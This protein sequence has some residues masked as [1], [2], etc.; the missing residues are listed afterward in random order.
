MLGF[1]D[2]I[3]E[4]WTTLSVIAARTATIKLG[5]IHL[6][7]PF[8]AQG[9]D[10]QDGGPL[11]TLSG[12]RLILFYDCGWLESEVRAYGLDGPAEDEPIARMAEG[13]DLITALWRT[14]SPLDFQGQ[15]FWTHGANVSA[16]AAAETAS[17]YLA[18]RSPT[19]ALAG[20]HC[21]SCGWLEQRAGQSGSPDRET[22]RFAGRLPPRRPRHGGAR[23]LP[24]GTGPG[25]PD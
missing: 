16:G 25:C 3:L 19:F 20:C 6:A 24:G 12:G 2:A 23:T 13:L 1:G 18:R 22:P 8:R 21:S 9:D 11:D 4:G 15:F 17:A 14:S 10:C 7:Q 5:T